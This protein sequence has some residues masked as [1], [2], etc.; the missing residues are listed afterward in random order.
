MSGGGGGMKVSAPDG[1]KVRRTLARFAASRPPPPSPHAPPTATTLTPPPPPQSRPPKKP[2]TGL[3]RHERQDLRLV[4]PRGQAPRSPQGRQ[5]PTP[6]RAP[7][8]L[9]LPGRVPAP[10]ADA[11]RA[12]PGG[13]RVPPAAGE[14][15]RV[16]SMID[17]Y[18]MEGRG[19]VR[20][21]ISF[22]LG[23]RASARGRRGRNDGGWGGGARTRQLCTFMPHTS[24]SAGFIPPRI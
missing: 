8:G 10:Q 18:R 21:G 13:Y 2:K 3:P 17:E 22:D 20:E 6:P 7:P 23:R 12:V 15:I 5:L 19:V 14:C 11:R 4:A 9:W 1:V 16:E 24:P